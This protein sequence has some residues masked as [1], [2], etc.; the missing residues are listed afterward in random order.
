MHCITGIGIFIC[1]AIT[2]MGKDASIFFGL[3]ANLY[4]GSFIFTLFFMFYCYNRV[5]SYV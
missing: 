3:F 1:N 2:A 5:L 4:G